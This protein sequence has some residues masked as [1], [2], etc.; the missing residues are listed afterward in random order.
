VRAK[1]DAANIGGGAEKQMS[2]AELFFSAERFALGGDEENDSA[3]G[4]GG[5]SDVGV[6]SR[7]PLQDASANNNNKPTTAAT[8]ATTK[9]S[10][11]ADLQSK[12]ERAMAV[13]LDSDAALEESQRERGQ[14][15]ES[16]TNAIDC[17]DALQAA[18]DETKSTVGA[19]QAVHIVRGAKELG[20]RPSCIQLR[21]ILLESASGFKPS[22]LEPCEP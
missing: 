5:A 2:K 19:V 14:L 7:P 20:A 12:L 16:L 8:G 15:E 9:P 22:T 18:A 6:K 4:S 21:P 17:A 11:V 1:E 3:L 10:K 13:V